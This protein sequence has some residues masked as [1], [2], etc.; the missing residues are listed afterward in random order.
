MAGIIAAAEVV[1]ERMPIPQLEERAIRKLRHVFDADGPEK[2]RMVDL[3]DAARFMNLRDV[4]RVGLRDARASRRGASAD[5]A[6]LARRNHNARDID[7]GNVSRKLAARVRGIAAGDHLSHLLARH[8]EK[9]AFRAEQR[10]KGRGIR[11]KVVIGKHDELVPMLAIPPRHD[12]RAGVT[13]GVQ[14]V[15]VRVTPKPRRIAHRCRD[16]GSNH[17]EALRERARPFWRALML[18]DHEV[19][20][21]QALQ[22][23]HSTLPNTPNGRAAYPRTSSYFLLERFSALTLN[24]TFPR[25]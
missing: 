5:A 14:R 3:S 15:G 9:L 12:V 16:E 6:A 23:F 22:N 11:Q 4:V 10:L 13:V 8:D 21:S 20:R 19:T 17:Q 1:D 7:G 18:R 2:I 25:S 24:V